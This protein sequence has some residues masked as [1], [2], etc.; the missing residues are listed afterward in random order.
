MR[1]S[2]SPSPASVSPPHRAPGRTAGLPSAGGPPGAAAAA[3][4]GG[5]LPPSEI[6][7]GACGAASAGF[8]RSGATQGADAKPISR[9]RSTRPSICLMCHSFLMF[10]VMISP[11]VGGVDS[12]DGSSRP[13]AR[14]SSS[15]RMR[16]AP[17]HPQFRSARP[18]PSRPAGFPWPPATRREA[19]PCR[20]ARCRLRRGEWGSAEAAKELVGQEVASK[21]GCELASGRVLA[22]TPAEAPREPVER[23]CGRRPVDVVPYF[24]ELTDVGLERQSLQAEA[25]E[26]PGGLGADPGELRPLGDRDVEAVNGESGGDPAPSAPAADAAEGREQLS[27]PP[28]KARLASPSPGPTSGPASASKSTEQYVPGNQP[29]QIFW[30]SSRFERSDRETGPCT[31][32][33]APL[34]MAV[35]RAESI[36]GSARGVS[37]EPAVSSVEYQSR[38]GRPAGPSSRQP[39]TTLPAAVLGG[40]GQR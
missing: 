3:A 30:K 25:P 20:S 40:S 31:E 38:P 27:T 8:A 19:R 29:A 24:R 9:E 39:S 10:Q 17:A 33:V 7:G 36:H 23:R 37:H 34:L 12:A 32:S 1:P 14:N 15:V 26:Q 16:S 13:F 22:M 2:P 21:R 18:L 4:T 6:P 11:A 28:E 5:R 35:K